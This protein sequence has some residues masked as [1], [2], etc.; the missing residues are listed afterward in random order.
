MGTPLGLVALRPLGH[1]LTNTLTRVARELK[2]TA[3]MILTAATVGWLHGLT[4]QRPLVLALTEE[5]RGGG[6]AEVRSG[7]LSTS[8]HSASMF[9]QMTASV[10]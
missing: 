4:G 9:A 5:G 1:A 6:R 2:T 7:I 8:S 10:T 3:P